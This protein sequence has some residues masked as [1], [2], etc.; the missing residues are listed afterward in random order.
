MYVIFLTS[1]AFGRRFIIYEVV[2]AVCHY[3]CSKKSHLFTL[4]RIRHR[5]FV[6]HYSL[7]DRLTS[8]AGLKNSKLAEMGEGG[9]QIMN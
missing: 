8:F 5:R 6:L 7:I 1:I 4:V 3:D 9:R 2:Y